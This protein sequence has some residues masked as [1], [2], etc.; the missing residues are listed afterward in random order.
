MLPKTI[1]QKQHYFNIPSTGH[2]HSLTL[3]QINYLGM[4]LTYTFTQATNIV[5]QRY[6]TEKVNYAEVP[7]RSESIWPA[8]SHSTLGL[9]NVRSVNRFRLAP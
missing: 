6:D 5:N 8:G 2:L 4:L 7:L 9:L 3:R 1:K